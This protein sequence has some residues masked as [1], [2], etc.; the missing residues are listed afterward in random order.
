MPHSL[1]KKKKSTSIEEETL[2][3]QEKNDLI[4]CI[5]FHLH[6]KVC[7]CITSCSLYFWYLAE[8][9]SIADSK[10]IKIS[11]CMDT[12]MNRGIKLWSNMQTIRCL[13]KY[14]L[15]WFSCKYVF[16]KL[17]PTSTPKMADDWVARPPHTQTKVAD[18]VVF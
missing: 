15:T 3:L 8:S 1:S 7:L 17:Y 5:S 6:T 13:V 10:Q 9:M 18:C 4:K 2:K 11:A 14:F 12:C 16:L